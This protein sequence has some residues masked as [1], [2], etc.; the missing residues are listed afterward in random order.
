MR[1][2]AIGDFQGVFPS[3]LRKSLEKEK[4]DLII[5]L[6]DYAGIEE[7]KPAIMKQ[8]RM[9]KQGKKMDSLEEI[10]GKKKYKELLKKDFMMGRTV[11]S[12]LDK[13]AK[14][15]KG[16]FIFGNT[17][18]E[19]YKYPFSPKEF[20]DK[21]KD[22]IIKKLKNLKNL[23]YK[24]TKLFGY[25]FIGFGGYMDIDAYFEKSFKENE[26]KKNIKERIKRRNKT[27]QKLTEILK[28]VGKDAVFVFHYPPKGAFDIIKSDRKNP[29]N[30]KSA[31]IS[32]FRDSIVRYKPKL[33]LCGHMHEYQGKK[34]IGNSLVVN[35][36]SAEI[37]RAALI[38]IKDGN[39]EIKVRFFK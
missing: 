9:A 6:G 20:F 21:K 26:D 22:K 19:W 38:D 30:G 16:L 4:F 3:K 10:L 27:K 8:I 28:G 29:M 32:F 33:V 7:W 5:G 24:K 37:G 11:L 35:P 25:S 34:K 2:L 36:G 31:G 14:D 1:I 17:D 13:L 39:G 18:D 23:N 15:K 12:K